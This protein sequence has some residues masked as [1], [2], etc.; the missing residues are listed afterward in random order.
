[1]TQTESSGFY[2][3]GI[4]AHSLWSQDAI[5]RGGDR[6]RVTMQCGR[7]G[8]AVHNMHTH[9]ARDSRDVMLCDY[10]RMAGDTLRERELAYYRHTFGDALDARN[11]RY[12]AQRHPPSI[13]APH[14]GCNHMDG[15]NAIGAP[16]P[17][18]HAPHAGCNRRSQSYDTT[19]HS[20][21]NP[22]T[23]CGVQPTVYLSVLYS[24]PESSK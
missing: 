19:A 11:E 13:H 6:M 12:R 2:A 20:P 10:T 7:Q 3:D 4:R 22:C 21:F 23:P 15:T 24:I 8:S 1:M 17:S 9:V 16:Q 14:A 18:I 5:K